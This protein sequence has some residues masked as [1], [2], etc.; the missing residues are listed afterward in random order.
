MDSA[1]FMQLIDDNYP[2]KNTRN[3]YKTRLAILLK[4][5]PETSLRSILMDPD[6]YYFWIR[7]YFLKLTTRK[8]MITTVLALFKHDPKLDKTAHNKWRKIHNELDAFQDAK[9]KRNL[10]SEKQLQQY[11]PF[12][13][14]EGKYDVLKRRKKRPETLAESLHFLLLSLVVHT[15][16]KRRNYGSVKIYNGKD[17]NIKN[18]NYLVLNKS[19]SFFVFKDFKTNRTFKRIDESVPQ[20]FIDDLQESLKKYPR[21]FLFVNSH[22]NPFDTNDKYGKFFS[23]TFEILFGKAM[24]TS[25]LRHIYITEKI[26]WNDSSLEEQESEAR[27]MMHST[28]VQR[29][30]KWSKPKICAYMCSEKK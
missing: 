2:N 16:P 11:I 26:D 13:E 3:M 19:N 29:Q 28:D 8:N 5:F 27:L 1:Y 12:E 23:K 22:K 10:P 7:D 24:G 9:Y 17:P 4:T 6:K 18:T 21:Q 20:A 30:Y 14:I 15:R 25:M